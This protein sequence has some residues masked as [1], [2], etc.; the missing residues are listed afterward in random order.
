[1]SGNAIDRSCFHILAVNCGVWSADVHGR[2]PLSRT[3]VTQLVTHPRDPSLT[4]LDANYYRAHYDRTTS[5]ASKGC[6]RP[7]LAAVAASVL[8]YILL[9]GAEA[10]VS[11]HLTQWMVSAAES[12]ATKRAIAQHT[13]TTCVL[14]ADPGVFRSGNRAGARQGRGLA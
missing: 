12:D 8:L 2:M 7:Y 13:C 10:K 4:P 1:V 14:A 3:V 6:L 9:Y 11:D 5:A